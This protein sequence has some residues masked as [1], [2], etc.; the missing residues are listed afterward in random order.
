MV[1]AKNHKNVPQKLQPNISSEEEAQQE[2]SQEEIGSE[3]IEYEE[4]E[5]NE[6]PYDENAQLESQDEGW[7]Q[8]EVEEVVKDADYE[9][10]DQMNDDA[11]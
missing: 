6:V 8:E 10:L 4:D 11:D 5:G 9:E 3:E 2:A 1:K 7:E